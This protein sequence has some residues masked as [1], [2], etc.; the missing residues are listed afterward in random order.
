MS[1]G[2]ESSNPCERRAFTHAKIAEMKAA[3]NYTG[4]LE[5][6]DE[7]CRVAESASLTRKGR[8][9]G[10]AGALSKEGVFVI[11]LGENGIKT[12]LPWTRPAGNGSTRR[13]GY[14]LTAQDREFL[15]I[16]S[17]S[18]Q[19]CVSQVEAD[20]AANRWDSGDIYLSPDIN[21]HG[22]PTLIVPE[23]KLTDEY[24]QEAL[25][26]HLSQAL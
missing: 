11:D 18:D 24:V 17:L 9:S 4:F 8:I 19:C 7:T 6:V 23:A 26:R 20:E 25:T 1:F 22:A 16:A 14:L 15:D 13:D 2:P 21:R 5:L 3:V 12:W 10:F